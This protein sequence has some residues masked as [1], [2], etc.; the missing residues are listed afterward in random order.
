MHR[1]YS[2]LLFCVNLLVYISFLTAVDI[3]IGLEEK[4]SVN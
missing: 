2:S 3:L 4:I 1:F